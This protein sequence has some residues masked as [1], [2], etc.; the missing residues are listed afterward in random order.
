MTISFREEIVNGYVISIEQDKFSVTYRV[1]ACPMKNEY[2]AGYPETSIV[3]ATMAEANKRFNYLKRK[4]KR[5]GY[6]CSR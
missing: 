3:Y 5:D 2:M 6:A 1:I 4:I